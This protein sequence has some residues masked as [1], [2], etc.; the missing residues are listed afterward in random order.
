MNGITE[1]QGKA[2][3]TGVADTEHLR[4]LIV[5]ATTSPPHTCISLELFH[6]ISPRS[7]R[8][9]VAADDVAAVMPAVGREILRRC[10]LADPQS[11]RLLFPCLC[12]GSLIEAT[13]VIL[14]SLPPEPHSL[15]MFHTWGASGQS[16]NTVHH[17][18]YSHDPTFS[19]HTNP[20]PF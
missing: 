3:S 10:P 4:I 2:L 8:T 7:V 1:L 19:T 11:G 9:Y 20:T 12:C 5:P 6:Q 17:L 13:P 16:L 18:G 15:C 14:W